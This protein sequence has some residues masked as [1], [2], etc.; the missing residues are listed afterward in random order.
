MQLKNFTERSVW[1]RSNKDKTSE[2]LLPAVK[3]DIDQFV[4]E[5]PQ[6]DNITMLCLEY[7]S[8]IE[9]NDERANY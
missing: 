8:A 7:K 3:A 2:Q 6:F 5:A 1:K 9:V 4:G